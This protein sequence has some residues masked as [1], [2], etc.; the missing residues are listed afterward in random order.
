MA[1]HDDVSCSVCQMWRL[2]YDIGR[3]YYPRVTGR[4]GP[5]I[6]FDGVPHLLAGGNDYL[7]LATDPRVKQA[8]KDAV[9]EF[10]VGITGSPLMNGHMAL[11]EELAAALASWVGKESAMVFTAG[12]LA[13]LGAISEIC[14]MNPGGMIAIRDASAHAS[15]IDGLRLAGV[16]TWKFRHNDIDSLRQ[17]L[18]AARERGCGILVVIDGVYSVEGDIAPLPDIVEVARA[19]GAEIFLD[20]AHGLGVLAEGRG[21]AAYFGMTDEVDYIS[22]SFSKAC[23][24]TGGFIAASRTVIRHFEARCSPHM[25]AAALPPAMAAATLTSLRIMREEPQRRQRVLAVAADLRAQLNAIGF[26]AGGQTAIVPVRMSGMFGPAEDP[27]DARWREVVGTLRAQQWLMEQGV[28][29][30]PFIPPG[31]PEPML[32]LSVTAAFTAEDVKRIVD[33]FGEML[34]LLPTMASPAASL[35]G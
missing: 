19:Y 4:S 7:D 20:D 14:Q 32:R 2:S 25:Y 22:A 34:P 24:A 30:N 8:A 5:S 23:G 35:M 33:A 11:H 10:G 1:L 21:T 3:P 6:E 12:Y 15:L 17:R 31:A 28:Y 18:D 13:N 26:A 29:V 16:R 9:D 27:D